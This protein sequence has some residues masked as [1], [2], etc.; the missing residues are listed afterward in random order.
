VES[1]RVG[2]DSEGV[3]G[4]PQDDAKATAMARPKRLPL[5]IVVIRV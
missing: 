4:V 2:A 3:S 5:M 1:E